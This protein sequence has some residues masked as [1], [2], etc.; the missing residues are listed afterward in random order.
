MK[1]QLEYQFHI[2]MF[3]SQANIRTV[4]WLRLPEYEKLTLRK[5]CTEVVDTTL[6]VYSWR[7][8]IEF[9]KLFC[10]FDVRGLK[11]MRSMHSPQCLLSKVSPLYIVYRSCSSNLTFYANRE[12][13]AREGLK[14]LVV[15]GNRNF[16]LDYTL[17][18]GF[19]KPNQTERVETADR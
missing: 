18:F 15:C 5:D 3:I 10:V 7:E 4:Y 6:H 12:K 13:L 11:V 9:M 19:W 1:P 16:R 17:G 14:Q 2:H 8:L